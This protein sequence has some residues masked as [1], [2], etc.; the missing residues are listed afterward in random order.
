ESAGAGFIARVRPA[1]G[2]AAAAALRQALRHR[3]LAYVQLAEDAPSAVLRDA[4]RPRTWAEA[5]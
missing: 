3:G 1:D 4:V 5:L 2:D